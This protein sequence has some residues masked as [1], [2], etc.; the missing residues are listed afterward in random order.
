MIENMTSSAMRK[1]FDDS[2]LERPV[3]IA[4]LSG[5]HNGSIERAIALI[6]KAAGHGADIIKFQHYTVD[7][8]T[9]RCSH[10]DFDVQGGTIWDGR[11]LADL[12]EEASMPWDW[13]GELAEACRRIGIE[14]FSSPFDASAVDFLES[15][16]PCGYKVASCELVDLPLIRKIAST[17]RPVIM[18]TGMAT[19]AE[20]DLAVGAFKDAGGRDLC[21]MRCNSSY[22]APHDEMDLRTIPR[23]REVWNVPIG[24]SDHSMS[25]TSA[26]VATVLGVRVI[27][28]HLTLS[29]SDGGPDAMFSLEP[30]EFR[31]LRDS[32]EETV[33]ALGSVRFGPSPKEYA[34]LRY[35]RSLRLIR[36]VE[37]GEKVSIDNVRSVRPAGGLLPQD[38]PELEGR[39]F[40]R[41]LVAGHPVSWMDVD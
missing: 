19:L 5:N 10:P 16:Q 6:E 40:R 34:S 25:V 27:E 13:T 17:G 12:Y 14:W 9:V 37:A 23:M 8:I 4:E 32:V 22:P 29:R 21:L 3:L 30:E 41:S 15:F 26:Q 36:D 39:I 18:S 31:H 35:R 24:L 38:F 11:Q 20:I 33:A 1:I 7:T 28:K 2:R